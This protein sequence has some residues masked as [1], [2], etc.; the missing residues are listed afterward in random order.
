MFLYK[1][2]V[3]PRR[4]PRGLLEPI[5]MSP[6][7]KRGVPGTCVPWD[8]TMGGCHPEG[9]PPGDAVPNEVRGDAVP[10]EVRDARLTLGRAR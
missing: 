3:T 10:N 8:D 4:Q 1:P 9:S 7:T 2:A 6:R 5:F